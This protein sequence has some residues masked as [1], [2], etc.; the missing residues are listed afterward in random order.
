MSLIQAIA[1]LFNQSK[2]AAAGP[3]MPGK[4]D[5]VTESEDAIKSRRAKAAFD[6]DF[7]SFMGP[8]SQKGDGLDLLGGIVRGILGGKPSD[9][10][11]N[12]LN[13]NFD[14]TFKK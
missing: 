12:D 1:G 14:R 6:L 7:E 3:V 10:A 4:T 9:L 11:R 8:P 13:R 2:G 5:P